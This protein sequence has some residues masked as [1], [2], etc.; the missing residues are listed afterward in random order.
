MTTPPTPAGWY[1]DPDGSGG[2]R[3][4]DGYTWTDHRYPAAPV[5]P[6]P[7][8]PQPP[9]PAEPAPPAQPAANEERTAI[10]QL[11]PVPT[12]T[13]VGAHRRP[14]PEDE[15]E[16]E[17]EP[18]AESEPTAEPVPSPGPSLNSR[19]TSGRPRSWPSVIPTAPPPAPPPAFDSP[20]APPPFDLS[21]DFPSSPQQYDFSSPAPQADFSPSGFSSSGYPSSFDSQSWSGSDTSPSSGPFPSAPLHD[22]SH[23]RPSRAAVAASSRCT[24]PR[25]R[26]CWLCWWASRS[27]GSSSRRTPR[28]K[29]PHPATPRPNRLKL[30]RRP[31]GPQASRP[32][33][34]PPHRR[35]P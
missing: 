18:V 23:R 10:V 35:R 15:P 9:A 11:R 30:R 21:S 7:A 6:P 34:P 28:C 14:D 32:R 16:P 12:E 17:P 4:W 8:P 27:T 25:A 31:T 5:S 22:T 1:P 3:Y 13:H 20:S 26:S 33:R 29:S 2:Q 19:R 24:S